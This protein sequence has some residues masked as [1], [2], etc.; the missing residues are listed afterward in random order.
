MI[1]QMRR[2]TLLRLLQTELKASPFIYGNFFSTASHK[3]VTELDKSTD[4]RFF[5]PSHLE[6]S[7]GLSSKAAISASQQL[8]KKNPDSV[9]HLLKD[10][11]L[12]ETNKRFDY[13]A[14]FVALFRF[15]EYRQAEFGVV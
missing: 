12:A 8:Q 14:S 9:L 7:R 1:T 6:N 4:P 3:P 15:G 10:Q 11:G 13:K 2:L 5:V